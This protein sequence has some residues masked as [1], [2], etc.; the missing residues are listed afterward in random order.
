MSVKQVPTI[1][2]KI[3]WS[4]RRAVWREDNDEIKW[5][6]EIESKVNKYNKLGERD[7]DKLQVIYRNGFDDGLKVT[8]N[9]PV[10]IHDGIEASTIVKTQRKKR[11][12]PNAKLPNADGII[13]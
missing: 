12:N 8:Y 11:R 6:N 13:I 4:K 1:L 9:T 3:A 5:L 10:S 2:K 7:T